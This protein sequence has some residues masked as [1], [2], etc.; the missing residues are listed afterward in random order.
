LTI[1]K[2]DALWDFPL[3]I[4]ENVDNKIIVKLLPLLNEFEAS[5][6]SVHLLN[7]EFYYSVMLPFNFHEDCAQTV[8]YTL[9]RC[10][11]NNQQQ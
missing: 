2:N 11:L 4:I 7:F 1:E 3:L 8:N 9:T 10:F 6:L 5:I